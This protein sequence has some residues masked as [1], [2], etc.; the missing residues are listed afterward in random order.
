M[1]SNLDLSGCENLRELPGDFK[2]LKSLKQLNL[3]NCKKLTTLPSGFGGL[4][5][6]LSKLNFIG[7]KNLKKLPHDVKALECLEID[8][9]NSESSNFELPENRI[10][11]PAWK[12][13]Q[14]T[15]STLHFDNFTV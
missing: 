4:G 14:E 12:N 1:L 10:K 6:K 3:V 2:D 7:C 8:S 11:G 15:M 13:I 5:A 9:E